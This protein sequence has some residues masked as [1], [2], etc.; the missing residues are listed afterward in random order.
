MARLHPALTHFVAAVVAATVAIA[1]TSYVITANINKH[2][3]VLP[4]EQA[5][6]EAQQ[7]LSKSLTIKFTEV[8]SPAVDGQAVAIL[9][10]RRQARAVI[11]SES[12]SDAE[13]GAAQIIEDQRTRQ[14]ETNATLR[15]GVRIIN[16]RSAPADGF[17]YQVA[18]IFSGADSPLYGL[19]CGGTLVDT[20]WVLTAAHCFNPDTQ[21]GDFQV[22]TGSRKLSEGGRLINIAKIVRY[23][24]EPTTNEGDVALV[25]LDT[26]IPDQ[27]PM[28]M[29]DS[30]LEGQKV[31]RMV[32]ISGWGVTAEG[33]S[34]AS[35]DLLFAYVPLIDNAVCRTDYGNLPAG[36]KTEIKDDMICAGEG[37]ADACQGDSGGPLIIKTAGNKPYLEGVVSWGEG[38]NRARFP[39]VY[40]RVPSYVSWIRSTMQ[41]Q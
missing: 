29:A 3:K 36:Q 25:K 21:N 13:K 23:N 14:L 7:R 37:K 34:T 33:S 18:L 16:G 4:S 26:P 10:S 41:S 32:T 40:A 22:F 31:T 9:R 28:S 6:R 11:N 8:S 27:A 30:A 39:G 24:Y 17:Q 5:V 20:S 19:H 12:S 1:V 2:R 15:P 35:D 38:C